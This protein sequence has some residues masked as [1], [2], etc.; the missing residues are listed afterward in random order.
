MSQKLVLKLGDSTEV[1]KT[2]EKGSVGG[3]VTDPPYPERT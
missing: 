2:L 3:I 1:M